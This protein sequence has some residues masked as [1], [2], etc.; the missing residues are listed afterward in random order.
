MSSLRKANAAYRTG[1]LDQAEALAVDILKS[2]PREEEAWLLLAAIADR[3]GQTAQSAAILKRALGFLPHAHALHRELGNALAKTGDL[4]QAEI[5]L[6]HA[7]MLHPED[8]ASATD[9]ARLQARRGVQLLQQGAFVN[10]LPYLRDALL[11]H[12]EDARV[13]FAVCIS[14]LSFHEPRPDL[15]LLLTRA[16]SEAWIRPSELV[17]VA[18]NLLRLE[19]ASSGESLRE[20]A[21]D[22]LLRALLVRTVI[23]NPDIERMLTGIRRTFLENPA[24]LSDWRD[25]AIALASQCFINEYAYAES[26]TETKAIAELQA[27]L[28]HDDSFA[29]HN[30]ILL[31]AYRPLYAEPQAAK[32]AG[33]AWGEDLKQLVELQIVEPREE[34]EIAKSIPRLTPIKDKISAAVQAQYEENPFPRWVDAPVRGEG[35][36]ISDWLKTHFPYIGHDNFETENPQIL[37]AGCG[38]GQ[39][40]VAS[41]RR[42]I[43]ADVLA[44]DLSLRSL[45]YAERKRKLLAITNVTYAQADILEL[46]SLNKEFD[47]VECAGVLHHLADPLAGWRVLK[48][49]TRPGGYMLLA[50]YSEHG[51]SELL[52]I[53]QFIA[54]G[55]YGHSASELRRFRAD[56]LALPED[57]PVRQATLNRD[58]F[59]SLSMLRDLVFHVEEHRFTIPQISAALK[60]LGL[61]FCGF[62]L[63]PEIQ[64]RFQAKFGGNADFRSL[65]SW[66]AFEAE[67]P[68]AFSAMYHFVVRRPRENQPA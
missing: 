19:P 53:R 23:A 34:I 21:Q 8:K 65:E 13:P 55:A 6:R 51:R 1:A 61:E 66:N 31:S 52:P 9:L 35:Q 47:I 36:K 38:T 28:A 56:I 68:R 62:G 45:G 60:E 39:E 17:R 7:A 44:V 37:V 5:Q 26:E 20:I 30:V 32:L 58:D 50:L 48:T 15:K 41:A 25:F 2:T 43:N 29:E 11:A 67:Y 27:R 24:M 57:H 16:I 3:R 49:L 12:N 59:Y 18:A 33:R 22:P 10:A 63:D 42:F 46:G 14:R 54:S 4:V 40:A 64:A